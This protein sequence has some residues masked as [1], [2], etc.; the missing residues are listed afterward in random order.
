M[1]FSH[2]VTEVLVLMNCQSSRYIIGILSLVVI[3]VENLC[4]TLFAF[5]CVYAASWNI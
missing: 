4:F 2:L 5:N 3:L 1:L